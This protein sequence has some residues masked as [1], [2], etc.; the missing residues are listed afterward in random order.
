MKACPHPMV[1]VRV[2]PLTPR[3]PSATTPSRPPARC[4]PVTDLDP[5]ALPSL[6][7]PIPGPASLAWLNRL[8]AVESANVTAIGDDFPVVWTAARGGAVQDADGNV[9]VDATSAFGVALIGHGHPAVVAAVQ[10]QAATLLHAMGDVHPAQAKVELL[11]ALQRVV[12]PGLGGAVLCT[13]GSE[14]VEVALKTALLVSGKPGVIAF[15][16]AYHGLGHGALDATSRRDFRTPFWTQLARNVAWVPFPRADR[17]PVGVVA[18][19]VAA[20]VLGRID[21]LLT[22]PS[23]GGMPIGALLLEPVQGR[24]GTVIPPPGFVS[25]LRQLCSDRGV[26]LIAD[27][28]FTGLGRTGAVWACQREGVVPD[29]LCIGKALGG[30]MPIAACVGRPE[31]MAAWGPSQGEALHTSTFLGHPVACAAATAALRVVVADDVPALAQRAGERW[32]AALH[33]AIGAHPAVREI[34]GA[35]LM[36]GIELRD[37]AGVSAKSRAWQLVVG[38]LRRGVV[39]LPAGAGGEVVQLTPPVVLSDAQRAAVV[40]AAAA[41]LDA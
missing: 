15:H 37:Y 31:V 18:G 19:D 10:R 28:I 7:T 5:N 26:L 12:P 21:E 35:G 36:I 32:I 34:R 30:G 41:A 38:A 1:V 23:A 39:L 11:E 20:H 17:P 9:Y 4:P 16:G 2:K 24:A 33:E 8:R 40:D 14:A 25:A 3:P 13:G 27:E 29:L 6:R 22:H